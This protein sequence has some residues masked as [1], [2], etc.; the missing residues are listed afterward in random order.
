[1]NDHRS[2]PFARRRL[3]LLSAALAVFA[4]Q[5]LAAAPAS[6]QGD[7]PAPELAWVPADARAILHLRVADLSKNPVTSKLRGPLRHPWRVFL[8]EMPQQCELKPQEL[9]SVTIVLSDVPSIT[10]ALLPVEVGRP[11][12]DNRTGEGKGEPKSEGKKGTEPPPDKK[13]SPSPAA[14]PPPQDRE[15]AGPFDTSFRLVIVTTTDGKTADRLVKSFAGNGDAQKE[16]GREFVLS[17]R[18]KDLALFRAGE[19]TV[20][21]GSEQ[22][23]RQA[24]KAGPAKQLAGELAPALRLVQQKYQVVLGLNG[25]DPVAD[26]FQMFLRDGP[27]ARTFRSLRAATGVALAI[28]F[29]QESRLAG[30]VTFPKGKVP[31]DGVPVVQDVL[32]VL[33]LAMLGMLTEQLAQEIEDTDD[34]A[35]ELQ[36]MTAV[37]LMERMQKGMRQAKVQ[38]EGDAVTF[39]ASAKTDVAELAKL[40][41]AELKAIVLDPAAVAERQ[42]RRIAS[43]LQQIGLALHTHHDVYKTFPP[44]GKSTTGKPLLSWRV[45]ILPYIE[46]VALFNKFKLDE[47]WDSAHNIK[48]LPLMPKIYA[49]VGL[50]TKEPHTTFLQAIVGPG[51][52]WENR[53]GGRGLRVID[54]TDGLSNTLM[55]VEASEAVPWTKPADVNY[56]PKKAV[57]KFGAHAKEGFHALFADGSVEFIRRIDETALRALITRNGGEPVDRDKFK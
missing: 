42:R 29:D 11:R 30:Q 6:A 50:K 26:G 36:A 16:N 27:V 44:P 28:S 19:R 56:D 13:P 54:F 17:K 25:A 23:V 35:E 48:L 8:H 3:A 1:M 33:R 51:A 10:E 57:P 34:P 43:N 38:Q 9:E 15:G 14:T 5:S 32:I 40:A 49:P 39:S 45:F 55:V 52:A 22:E 41:A 53:E 4:L 37:L 7:A 47:P 46:Q 2:N 20:V 24:L 12:A 18:E 21:L 31:A